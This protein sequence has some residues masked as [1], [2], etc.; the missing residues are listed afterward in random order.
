MMMSLIV[1]LTL[2]APKDAKDSNGKNVQSFAE[3]LKASHE[4]KK[5]A[6]VEP[7]EEGADTEATRQFQ[8]RMTQTVAGRR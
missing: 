2:V 7:E 3:R 8:V 4:L 1:A 5:P 6:A